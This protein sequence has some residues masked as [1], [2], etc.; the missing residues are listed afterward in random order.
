MGEKHVKK[1]HV[2]F[3]SLSS[4]TGYSDVLSCGAEV[5]VEACKYCRQAPVATASRANCA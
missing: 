3:E 4:R 1:C 2:Q 5:E